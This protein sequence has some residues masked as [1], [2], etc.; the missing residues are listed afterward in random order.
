[1]G[2]D[3]VFSFSLGLDFVFPTNSVRGKD[4][5]KSWSIIASLAMSMKTKSSIGRRR[6]WLCAKPSQR[7]KCMNLHFANSA[8]CMCSSPF[9]PNSFFV[10]TTTLQHHAMKLLFLRK[11]PPI[12]LSSAGV[13]GLL[14]HCSEDVLNLPANDNFHPSKSKW[15]RIFRDF[16]PN[17]ISPRSGKWESHEPQLWPFG[18]SSAALSSFS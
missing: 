14:E 5:S 4:E 8:F 17:T 11:L 1:M 9:T 3:A 12:C 13:K 6:W 10:V 2:Y 18:G 16:A 15:K 7:I